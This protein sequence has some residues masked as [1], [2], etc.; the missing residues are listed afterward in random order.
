MELALSINFKLVLSYE[1]QPESMSNKENLQL[2]VG[3]P[4]I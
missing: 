4:T 2:L 1:G 3:R